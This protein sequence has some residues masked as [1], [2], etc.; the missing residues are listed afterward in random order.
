[1]LVSKYFLMIWK[2]SIAIKITNCT[3]IIPL[4]DKDQPILDTIPVWYSLVSHF[5]SLIDWRIPFIKGKSQFDLFDWTF[6]KSLAICVST[7]WRVIFDRTM[8]F[9]YYF[10]LPTNINETIRFDQSILNAF[11]WKLRETDGNHWPQ[12]Q[13]INVQNSSPKLW[14]SLRS[15][16]LSIL[17]LFFFFFLKN[18]SSFWTQLRKRII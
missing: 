2:Q 12:G 9:D 13:E 3:P 10:S 11:L 4:D 7:I 16:S 17:F 1:M 8:N 5:A 15:F 6:E 18:F 14:S